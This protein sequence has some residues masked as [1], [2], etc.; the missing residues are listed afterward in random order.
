MKRSVRRY[1]K[2]FLNKYINIL[3]GDR[4][5]ISKGWRFDGK[6]N[7]RVQNVKTLNQFGRVMVLVDSI[8]TY[9]MNGLLHTY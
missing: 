8:S 9:K 7:L 6:E 4:S 1:S 2:L 3:S 5:D